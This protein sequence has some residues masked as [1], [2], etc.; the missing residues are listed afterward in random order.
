MKTSRISS[1]RDA[2]VALR[3]VRD[4]SVAFEH[5]DRMTQSGVGRVHPNLDP[6]GVTREC[7]DT[8]MMPNVTPIVFGLDVT[9]SRGN[10]ARIVYEQ[11]MPF[12]GALFMSG[13]VTDP[14]IMFAAIGDATVD[15]APLQIGQ[16]E[17]DERMD[18]DLSRMWLEKGGGGTGQESY[19]N[20]AYF[21]ARK[22]RIDAITKRGK[23]GYCHISGDEAPY[24][25]VDKDEVERLFGDKI[26]K[27]IP[28]PEIFAELQKGFRTFLYYTAKPMVERQA[29]IDS[30]IRQRLLKAG[31]RFENCSIRATLIWNT[32]DDLDLHVVTPNREH[33]FYGAPK[34]RCGGELDVDRN[35]HAPYTREPVENIRWPKGTAKPGKYRVFVQNYN[36]HEERMRDIPYKVELDIDGTV[37]T[38]EGVMKA[39]VTRGGSDQTAFEF[40]YVPAGMVQASAEG[41]EAYAD[42]V[43]LGAWRKC[44][45]DGHIIR[46]SDARWTTE[47]MIGV[48]AIQSG[49]KTLTQVLAD[50]HERAVDPKGIADVKRALTPFAAQAVIDE[51]DEAAF[52]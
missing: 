17:S 27:N 28:T 5:S 13:A 19:Q 35:A 41:R 30:E 45:P 34:S 6:K 48:M 20:L 3:S 11:T 21:L 2:E 18:D 50:M 51:V 39:G 10:D 49:K 26:K 9:E 23:K 37:T 38:F 22:T 1:S 31:G 14:Q 29:D 40:D 16:F 15:T 43:I 47:A 32:K 12:L 36:H 42:E 8:P 7:L 44:I 33:I 4:S 24:P 46:L 25:F 52:A